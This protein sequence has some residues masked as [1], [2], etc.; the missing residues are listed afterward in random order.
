MTPFDLAFVHVVNSPTGFYSFVHEVDG[1]IK[2]ARFGG[3]MFNFLSA[4]A[5][6]IAQGVRRVEPHLARDAVDAAGAGFRRSTGGALPMPAAPEAAISG[7]QATRGAMPG[8][9]PVQSRGGLRDLLQNLKTGKTPRPE[10]R[11]S[12]LRTP[13]AGPQAA[14][15]NAVPPRAVAPS[16]AAVPPP[17]ASP[18]SRAAAPPPAAVAPPRA[19]SP[20]PAAAPPPRAAPSPAATDASPTD[21]V[22]WGEWLRAKMHGVDVQGLR[23]AD[24]DYQ[25][26]RLQGLRE[27]WGLEPAPAAAP[28]VAP[29]AGAAVAPGFAD[30]HFGFNALQAPSGAAPGSALKNWWQQ[31]SDL[32]KMKTLGAAGL[33]GLGAGMALNA[34]NR[35]PAQPQIYHY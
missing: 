16:S 7:F 6:E 19:A 17:A 13:P 35:G 8:G 20:P 26:Q 32:Q 10:P 1:L 3:S 24:A 29:P 18:P 14:W 4:A 15:A 25:A 21:S 2:Q 22:G 31:S 11:A 28:A 23:Q 27:R 12:Q 5:P 30:T 9:V 33:G 34:T